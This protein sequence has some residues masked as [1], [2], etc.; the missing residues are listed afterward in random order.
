MYSNE[1]KSTKILI[2]VLFS[3]SA[4]AYLVCGA[5]SAE[6]AV[7]AAKINV[8]FMSDKRKEF[9]FLGTKGQFEGT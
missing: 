9:T 2:T 5:V 1:K 6:R 3:V 7:N 8:D 4:V